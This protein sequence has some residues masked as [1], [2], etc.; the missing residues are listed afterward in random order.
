MDSPDTEFGIEKVLRDEAKAIH[1]IELPEG[2]NGRALYRALNALNSAA[3]A[4]S[5][6][7]IR[8]AA[9]ALGIIQALATHPRPAGGG[10]VESAEKS[11]LAKFHYLST[12]SGGGYIGSWLSALRL[13]HGFPDI[14]AYLIG[15]PD[16]PDN[17]PPAIG[18]LRSYSNYLTPRLGVLS[19]DTWSTVALSVRNL[20][21][22]WLI[23]VPA[24]CALILVIKIVGI[25]SDWLT[26]PSA[27]A[28][29]LDIVFASLGVVC[30]VKA[31]AFTVHHRP[32]REPERPPTQRQ[33]IWHGLAFSI[34]ASVFIVQFMA[35]D[36]FD[37]FFLKNGECC[38]VLFPSSNFLGV[39][40]GEDALIYFIA[41]GALCGVIIY[42]ASWLIG[43][44]RWKDALDFVMWAAAGAVF[45]AL[46]ALGLY[47]WVQI[48]E[49]G[50]LI[51]SSV[52]FDLVFG[53][54]WVLMSQT[55]AEMI[56][57]GLASYQP[58]SDEDREWLGR[59]S[60]LLVATA[61]AWLL[62]SFFVF[63]GAVIGTNVLSSG[64]QAAIQRFSGPIAGLSGIVTALLGKSRLSPAIGNDKGLWQKITDAIL[65]SAALIF[66][67]A[68]FVGLSFALDHLLLGENLVPKLFD[69]WA[70]KRNAMPDRPAALEW[71]IAGFVIFA[72]IGA[73][74]SKCININR[75]SLHSLYRNRLIRAFL[76]AH[77]DRHPDPFIDF[78]PGDNPRM[79]QLWSP[80]AADNW[81][82]FH[83]INIALNIVT[84]KQLAWQERKAEPFTVSALHSGTGCLGFRSSQVYGGED[85][86]TLGTAMAISGA[87][88]SPNMGYNSSPIIT[89][90]MTLFNVRLGWW[91]GNPGPKGNQSYRHDGPATAIKSLLYEAF[92]LTTDDRKYV[93]LSDGGHFENLGLYEMVRRRCR[94][95]LVS[96]AGCDPEFRFEALGNAVR[97]IEI[98]LGV[99]IRFEKLEAL[100]PRGV[101]ASDGAQ[102]QSY[103][104][105][106]EVDYRAA[107]GGGENGVILYV[108]PAFHGNESAGIRSYAMANPEFPHQSTIDQWF[109]ESQFESYRALGFEIMDGVLSQTLSKKSNAENPSL[110]DAFF[111]A[112]AAG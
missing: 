75:F 40:P 8:S 47:F 49:Q 79:Q 90:L 3:L 54:P 102:V 44:P 100:K 56:F 23:I 7:G 16:G 74:T 63:F 107:D 68:L 28:L 19:A 48:P 99:R 92:G 2:M 38:D 35:S 22:N 6:G 89:F 65:S 21:L 11:L 93:Y 25:G 30:L 52:V 59:A 86:I 88:A 85:G 46:V 84:T 36:Y 50:I 17:E 39:D 78:D 29:P 31:L 66:F 45:G 97:K 73:G 95:I 41:A 10:P 98:D 34:A 24:V 43:W 110:G 9:F 51:F 37:N 103:H 94:F 112:N 109:T 82:P 105:I 55:I 64:T 101:D 76:G 27:W 12:V 4:L 70:E 26:R 42:A 5:G 13:R 67:A 72:V 91:L 62:L 15:R 57:V 71:F 104:A 33:V 83:I 69:D 106:A 58:R 77:S 60:G 18:W 111:P 81:R 96:D 14:W 61:V 20:I 87:A 1:G 80:V 108:K 32:S 53:I